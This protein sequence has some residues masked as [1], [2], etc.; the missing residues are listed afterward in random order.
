MKRRMT[1]TFLPHENQNGLGL[2]PKPLKYLVGDRG[3][4]PR[5]NGLRELACKYI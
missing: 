1:V 2:S 4:E 5:T 3:V